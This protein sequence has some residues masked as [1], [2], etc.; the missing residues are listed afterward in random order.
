MLE[1]CLLLQHYLNKLN[2]ALDLMLFIVTLKVI[3]GYLIA[4]LTR[5]S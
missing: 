5:S 4:Y 2:P 3:L 1:K